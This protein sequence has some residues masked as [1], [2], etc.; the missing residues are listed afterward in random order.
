M[1]GDNLTA[2]VVPY[3]TTHIIDNN[4]VVALRHK[5]RTARLDIIGLLPLIS[6]TGSLDLRYLSCTL[7]TIEDMLNRQTYG[8]AIHTNCQPVYDLGAKDGTK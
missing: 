7:I 3:K 8:Q 1:F 5:L 6:L 4:T 2:L